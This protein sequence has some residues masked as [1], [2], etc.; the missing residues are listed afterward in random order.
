MS[1]PILTT[2]RIRGQIAVGGGFRAVNL[3]GLT[4]EDVSAPTA[5]R[6]VQRSEGG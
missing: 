1:A 2:E 5:I 4:E 6:A 3:G